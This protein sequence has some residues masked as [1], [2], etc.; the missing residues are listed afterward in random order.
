[1][2]PSFA[3]ERQLLA[4]GHGA[5][6]GTDEVGR[7]PLAGPVVAAAVILAADRIPEGL[8]DSKQL[9]KVRREQLFL[10]IRESAR[11]I[12][13]AA[14]PAGAIDT[15]NIRR[16][17]LAAMQRA[18]AALAIAPGHVLVDGRDLPDDLPCPATALIGGDSR[19]VSIA[20][21]SIVAKVARDA[22]MARLDAQFPGYG[23]AANAGYPTAAHRAALVRIGPSPVH[24]RSFRLTA[25]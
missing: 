11:A 10:A 4:S 9:T 23:F 12:A 5:V 17:S 7:G 20:A 16:A 25:P 1:M 2:Q 13:I 24:R 15:L 18:V 6:A 19:S 14:L 22:M 21:A 3:F 8:R